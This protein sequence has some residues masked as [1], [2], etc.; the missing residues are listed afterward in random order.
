MCAICG[1]PVCN[2]ECAKKPCNDDPMAGRLIPPASKGIE[3]NVV[4]PV[5]DDPV[6]DDRIA[7][8]IGDR[9]SAFS[10]N[11]VPTVRRGARSSSE[12]A[13]DGGSLPYHKR[14]NPETSNAY[15]LDELENMQAERDP[16]GRSREEAKAKRNE[17]AQD[18]RHGLKFG[19]WGNDVSRS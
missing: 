1:G 5:H 12:V 13:C 17:F 8:E 15:T 14:I 18:R 7:S 4:R 2:R 3:M 16:M 10:S 6:A 11:T 9:R 19:N